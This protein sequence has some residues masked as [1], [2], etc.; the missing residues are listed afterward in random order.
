VSSVCVIGAGPAGSTFAAR[1]AQLGHDVCLVERQSF[2]RR[3]LGESLSPG[4]LPLLDMTGA[5]QSVEAAR[6]R[7]VRIVRVSRA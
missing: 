5:R 2:P 1:M 4:V 7:R 3:Q 6:F